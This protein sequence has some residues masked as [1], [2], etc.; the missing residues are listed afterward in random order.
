MLEQK[1]M[2]LA[3]MTNSH[4]LPPA[5]AAQYEPTLPTALSAGGG[6]VRHDLS[7]PN[8]LTYTRTEALRQ[9]QRAQQARAQAQQQQQAAQEV[10]MS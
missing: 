7:T 8:Y 2:E 3:L 4:P 5:P 1:F 6:P 9:Q 10:S